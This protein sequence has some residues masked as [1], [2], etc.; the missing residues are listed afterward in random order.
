MLSIGQD[1]ELVHL[2]RHRHLVPPVPGVVGE[3]ELV[4]RAVDHELRHDELVTVSEGVH[5]VAHLEELGMLEV[6]GEAE[7][8]VVLEGKGPASIGPEVVL[9]VVGYVEEVED[10]RH[11]HHHSR[12]H[13]RHQPGRPASLVRL[14][15]KRLGRTN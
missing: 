7:L 8:P 5:D 6:R 15:D 14:L 2:V 4:V 9:E 12:V 11:Q 1:H 13:S 3:E 10:D